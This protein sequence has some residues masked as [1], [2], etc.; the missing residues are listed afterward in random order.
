MPNEPPGD[1]LFFAHHV[2]D[3]A[4]ALSGERLDFFGRLEAARTDGHPEHLAEAQLSGARRRR[5]KRCGDDC[6]GEQVGRESVPA[7][8]D[9]EQQSEE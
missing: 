6:A 8:Q 3:H 4:N 1:G 5:S 9:G 2:A 7:A